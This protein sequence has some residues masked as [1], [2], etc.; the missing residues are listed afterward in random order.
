MKE[1]R[2]PFAS[3]AGVLHNT[4][5]FPPGGRVLLS[6]KKCLHSLICPRGRVGFVALY[7]R[8]ISVYIVQTRRGTRKAVER[9]PHGEEGATIGVANTIAVR[10]AATR[11]GTKLLHPALT[12]QRL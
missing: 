12:R 3:M 11:S 8:N 7:G 6:E 9:A 1:S 5:P 4:R 10:G 2:H